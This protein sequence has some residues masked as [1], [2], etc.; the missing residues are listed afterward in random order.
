MLQL[1]T[2]TPMRKRS[3]SETRPLQTKNN[4]FSISRSSLSAAPMQLPPGFVRFF[5]AG[6]LGFPAK[7]KPEY[8]GTWLSCQ[9]F[10]VPLGRCFLVVVSPRPGTK[11]LR[12]SDLLDPETS[13]A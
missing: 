4:A 6:L 8:G 7:K 11:S 13:G 9:D 3:K 1:R 5:S 10:S 12:S 2:K